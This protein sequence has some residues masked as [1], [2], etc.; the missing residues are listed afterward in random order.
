M[1]GVRYSLSIESRVV[2]SPRLAWWGGPVRE[3]KS[4]R[5]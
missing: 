5:T 3:G 4:G 2:L 1:V